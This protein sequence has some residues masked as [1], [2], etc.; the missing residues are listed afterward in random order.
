MKLSIHQPRRLAWLALLLAAGAMLLST[1]GAQAA[2]N[3]G[4][5]LVKDIHPGRSGS[6]S[7]PTGDAAATLPLTSGSC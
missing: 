2:A 1:S 6:S 4:A 3:R 7:G 5:V